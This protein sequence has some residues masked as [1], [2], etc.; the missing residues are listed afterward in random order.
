MGLLS[1]L[2]DRVVLRG[3]VGRVSNSGTGY[4]MEGGIVNRA[5]RCLDPAGA[6][7]G[8]TA[9]LLFP[10]CSSGSEGQALLQIA[11]NSLLSQLL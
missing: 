10:Q 7:A 9:A 6:A 5:V 2:W 3:V 4:L 8:V 1:W 11:F